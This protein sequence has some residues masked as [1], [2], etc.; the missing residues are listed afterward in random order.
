MY[1]AGLICA[2]IPIL[3]HGV[4]MTDEEAIV[5]R[6]PGTNGAASN[7][8]VRS[9]EIGLSTSNHQ[10]GQ[11]GIQLEYQQPVLKLYK[12]FR[13]F[14]LQ[15]PNKN[16]TKRDILG[17][18]EKVLVSS[19][20]N[21]SIVQWDRLGVYV[22]SGE[23]VHG[24]LAYQSEDKAQSLFYLYGEFDGWLL[25]PNPG[26][27]FGGIKSLHDEMCVHSATSQQLGYWS[28]YSGPTDSK[29]PVQAAPHWREDDSTLRVSCVPRTVNIDS[30][31]INNAAR[32]PMLLKVYKQIRDVLLRECGGQL[33]RR[34]NIDA[35]TVELECGGGPCHTTSISIQVVQGKADLFLVASEDEVDLTR[36]CAGCSKYWTARLQPDQTTS[37]RTMVAGSRTYLHMVIIGYSGYI[38]L[39]IKIHST[40][41]IRA[42]PVY[43]QPPT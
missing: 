6:K 16:R 28:Y 4:A 20:G 14:P 17:C 15:V 26:T 31:R 42:T 3:T 39:N 35:W 24:R 32:A 19:L 43:Y 18:C 36:I 38:S 5:Y 11:Q 13:K 30:R 34:L 10:Q 33:S 23:R 2:I 21:A 12:S 27:N 1:L 8:G 25:G 7:A 29:D 9:T 37:W 22:A 40:N 41:I